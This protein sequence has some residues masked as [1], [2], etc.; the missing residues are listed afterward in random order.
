MAD[1]FQANRE[2]FLFA[3]VINIFL[4]G[5]QMF[6]IGIESFLSATANLSYEMITSY[7]VSVLFLI[8][9][10]LLV[11]GNSPLFKRKNKK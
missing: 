6:R 5:M 9:T 7:L 2:R 8:V 4:L 1:F 11:K 10:I 3:L